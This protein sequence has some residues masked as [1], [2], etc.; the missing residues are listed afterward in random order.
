MVRLGSHEYVQT[1]RGQT[2]RFPNLDF[3]LKDWP[4][5]LSPHYEDLRM[6][7]HTELRKLV[8]AGK[9]YDV[10][11]ATDCA[12]LVAAWFPNASWDALRLASQII[13][14]L[15]LWDDAID[16]PELTDMVHDLGA[17]HRFRQE[18]RDQFNRYLADEPAPVEANDS[19]LS[20]PLRSFIPVGE[21]LAFR[22]TKGQRAQIL[23]ELHKYVDACEYEQLSELSGQAPAIEEYLRR[24]MGTSAVGFVVASLEY[25]TGI[26]LGD[27]IRSDEYVKAVF[28][29]TVFNIAIVN[30]LFSLRRE[31]QH[32]FYNNA[33]AV[34]YHQYQELQTAVD[35]TYRII[36]RGIEQLEDAGKLALKRFPERHE[37]LSAWIEGCKNM[38]T[39]NVLWSLH[40]ARYALGVK[41]V[42]GTTEITI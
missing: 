20:P 5:G 11:A 29:E 8:G 28:D 2:L 16:S 26:D 1:L 39:G 7:Q 21:A 24:R 35:E 27:M 9:A 17:S 40:N 14:F 10:C 38:C 3:P 42:D 31:L 12:Y 30:D 36:L 34:L 33:V 22:T 4:K 6:V 32:P 19:Q 23:S 13:T 18:T 15:Y 25:I 41:A 37:D